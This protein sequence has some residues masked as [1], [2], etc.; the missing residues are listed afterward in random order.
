MAKLTAL[1]RNR[2][3][4]RIL[5][6]ILLGLIIWF[7]GPL[8]A[9]AGFRPLGWWPITLVFALLPIV[10]VVVFWLLASQREKKKNAQM[11]E[12]LKP[13]PAPPTA[14]SFPPSWRRRWRC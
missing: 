1:F 10:L 14:T 13:D 6:A 5:G 2:W 8:I 12:A 3:F 7:V 9:I 4:W 11:I